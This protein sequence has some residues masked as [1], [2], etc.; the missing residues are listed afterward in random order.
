MKDLSVNISIS[1]D[2]YTK[3]PESSELGKKIVCKSI[4]MINDL[5]FEK[6][7]FKK[8]GA[9]IG[10][11][12]SSI[13]RYFESKHTLLIYLINWYWGWIEYKLVFLNNNLASPHVRLNNAIQLFT[14]PVEKDDNYLFIN[15]FLLNKIIISES[16]KAYY[17]KDIDTENEKGFYKTYKRVVERVSDTILEINPSFKFPHML[18]STVIE[19]AHHQ[20]YFEKHIP[21]LTDVEDGENSIVQFYTDLVRKSII[22]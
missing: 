20:K 7:T 11:N 12:E 17:T 2:L 22:T 19:G 15:E 21:S 9:S 1:P 16:V 4:E 10:S 6:F 13:Y 5:G 14:E 18:I 8:L 3:N